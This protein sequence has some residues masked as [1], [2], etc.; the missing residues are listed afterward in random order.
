MPEAS[1]AFSSLMAFA[2][3]FGLKHGFDADHLASIDGLAR[4]QS[5]R[6]HK[7]LARSAGLLFSLG[8]GMTVLGAAWIFVRAGVGQMPQ[9]LE[10]LG[11][12]IS[13]VFLGS[14]GI[15]NLC[16][17][18]RAERSTP[19]ASPLARLIARLP[20]PEG[21]FGS[22]LVGALFAVS[23][24][25]MS[26]AAWF[27]LAGSRHDGMS[28]TLVL[29]L[30][31]V[32]GM[33]LTDTLN[34][35]VVASL[36]RRSERFVQNASRLF[37]LLVA[38]SALLVAGLGVSKLASDVFDAWADGKELLFGALVLTL[39]LAGYALARR[40]SQTAEQSPIRL[41]VP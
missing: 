25:A 20:L 38:A 21:F 30:C 16:N 24:D 37:S 7:R 10:P 40:I 28:A 31:F 34:G 13:I 9:W 11:A 4:L 35:L 36:I 32:G 41:P 19:V 23:F 27:G 1:L 17:V 6:G 12:W 26:L 15:V 5:R 33:I 22:I 14:I 18:M 8:H 29:A 3:L 39:I 2:L